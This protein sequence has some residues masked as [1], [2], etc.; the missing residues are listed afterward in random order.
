MASRK[1]LTVFATL[2]FM[3]SAH[4][5][6][7]G[8]EIFWALG[9]VEGTRQLKSVCEDRFPQYKAQN[10]LAFL[11]SPYARTTAEELIAQL[12]EGPQKTK[13]QQVL[14]MVRASQLQKYQSMNLSSL[15][16]MC[17]E[18]SDALEKLREGAQK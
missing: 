2:P 13:L 10:E 3:L 5:S 15:G 18:F 11:A 14:P 1:I 12:E 6:P 4:A 9:F 16:K 17:A 8:D 7:R